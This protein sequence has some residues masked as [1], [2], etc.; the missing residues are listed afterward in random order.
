MSRSDRYRRLLHTS[1]ATTE[2]RY[3]KPAVSEFSSCSY[4]GGSLDGSRLRL[5]SVG[6]GVEM[7]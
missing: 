1:N 5:L 7:Y 2:K 3:S 6:V 4:S